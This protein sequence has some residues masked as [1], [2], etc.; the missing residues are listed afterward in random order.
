MRFLNIALLIPT[1]IVGHVYDEW[2]VNEVFLVDDELIDEL[3]IL[4]ELIESVEDEKDDPGDDQPIIT[5][6]V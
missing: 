2:M 1:V 6:T 5:Q 3:S 4:V